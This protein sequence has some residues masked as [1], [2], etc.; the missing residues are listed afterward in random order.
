MLCYVPETPPNRP[1]TVG[2]F[3]KKLVNR[4]HIPKKPPATF[5][6]GGLLNGSNFLNPQPMCPPSDVTFGRQPS[7]LATQRHE[8]ALQGATEKSFDRNAVL[9]DRS[10]HPTDYQPLSVAD[11]NLA[12]FDQLSKKP[13]HG[14]GRG[15]AWTGSP[16]DGVR[17]TL[18]S[19]IC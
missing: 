14:V 3:Y 6:V 18:F 19:N 7:K 10:S 5:E 2:R 9:S 12:T 13:S 11:K 4:I 17:A 1:R 16:R 15:R 8:K